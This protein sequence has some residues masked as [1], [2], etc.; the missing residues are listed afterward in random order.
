MVMSIESSSD[1]SRRLTIE[2]QDEVGQTAM[3][4]NQLMSAQQM[5]ISEVNAVVGAIAAGDFSKRVN[6]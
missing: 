4:F 1:F 5:A 2:S 6:A 3:A